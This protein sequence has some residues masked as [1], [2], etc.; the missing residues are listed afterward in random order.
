MNYTTASTSTN[1]TFT[2]KDLKEVLGKLR[3]MPEPEYMLV[4]PDGRILRG[5]DPWKLA[6][7]SGALPEILKYDPMAEIAKQGGAS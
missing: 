5:K 7:M 6:A 2:L 3:D 4:C 1:K